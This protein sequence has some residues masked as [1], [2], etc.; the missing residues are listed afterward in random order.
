M[1]RLI[2][3][4]TALT[5]CLT[6]AAPALAEKSCLRV[7]IDGT[8]KLRPK[9]NAAAQGQAGN[10]MA[11]CHTNAKF[12][13]EM[14]FPKNGGPN[15]S[16]NNWVAITSFTCPPGSP[17]AN[18]KQIAEPDA[19][20]PRPFQ[21]AGAANPDGPSKYTVEYRV[22]DLPPMSP[23]KITLQCSGPPKDMSDYGANYRQLMLP[24]Y[25]EKR[26][27][28][29]TLDQVSTKHPPRVDLPPFLNAEV[30]WKEQATLVPCKDF[31]N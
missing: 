24:W 28:S 11:S 23:F 1:F 17:G 27:F 31:Q 12:H 22:A 25:L 10:A 9:N 7:Q 20:K 3:I 8:I 14:V 18:C 15:I 30:Q 21:L 6:L 16:Q 29:V 4:L 26:V 5:L 19:Y 2:T 13:L